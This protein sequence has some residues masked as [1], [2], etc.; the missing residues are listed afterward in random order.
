[1]NIVEQLS[2]INYLDM[3]IKDLEKSYVKVTEENSILIRH[4]QALEKENKKLKEKL[5]KV[6]DNAQIDNI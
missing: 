1:M 2:R 5:K 3:K 6:L 4:N